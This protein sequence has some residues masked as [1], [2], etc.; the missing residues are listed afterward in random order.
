MTA[1]Q[2]MITP[3][4]LR[5]MNN[6]LLSLTAVLL[7]LT[8]PVPTAQARKPNVV[9]IVADDQRHDAMGIVQKELG[10]EATFPF[11]QS[12][13][14]DR[15]ATE[16]VR[17]RN[18]FVVHSLCSPSR[19]T[20]L[21]GLYTH[22]HGI[23]FNEQPFVSTE[24]WPHLLADNGWKTGY[25]GK[26]HMGNQRQRPGFQ[27]VAT[28]LNQGR[29][30]DCPF[31]VNGEETP[32]QGWVDDVST[33]YAIDFIRR[34][35]AEPFA[36]YL[37]FKSPHD[38]RTPAPRHQRTYSEVTIRKPSNWNVAAP[39]RKDAG[40]DWDKRHADRLNYFKTIAGIDDNIGRL[41]KVL[42]ETGL[43]EDTLV[44]YMGDNGYYLGEHGLGDKRTAYDESMRIP[45]LLRYPRVVR[46]SVRDELVLNL[47]VAAT[48]L[49]ACG[50]APTWSQHGASLM[51]LI[52]HTRG[53]VPWRK[54]FLYENY[55]DP[56]YP[57]VTFDVLAVRT[58]DFKY[59]THPGNPQWT[60]LF[61]LQADP[62]ENRNLI[63][64]PAS[65]TIRDEMQAELAR[66]KAEIGY[67]VPVA[68]RME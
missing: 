66:L 25:F 45:F 44:I 38:N 56:A 34:N 52:T 8:Y 62:H 68:A 64:D 14:M 16:G 2:Q 57:Q 30:D 51:P 24:T 65:A 55:R 39:W 17:F 36:M 3:T 46:P 13:H 29:Y 5:A 1:S 63:D 20:V 60:Q 22:E 33:D 50:L 67:S 23:T 40:W 43:A 18:S 7:L 61:D 49:D 48:L 6:Y 28:F 41:L 42:D 12:P 47:D 10:D 59:V 4:P 58:Q 27:E 21:S 15:L 26:W 32:S 35:R 11:F 19:A 53:E 37:G 31:L 9:V 54:S